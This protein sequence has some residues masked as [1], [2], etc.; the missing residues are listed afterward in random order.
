MM[1]VQTVRDKGPQRLLSAGSPAARGK[2][3]V[4]GIPKRVSYCV[5]FI[6][7]AYFKNVAAGRIIHHDEPRVGDPCDMKCEI[8]SAY[9]PADGKVAVNWGIKITARSK[10]SK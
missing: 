9:V 6:I 5:I 10:L 8:E 4:S 2:I 7:F 1:G 3:T